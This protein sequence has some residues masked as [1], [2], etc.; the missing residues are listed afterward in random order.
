MVGA[1]VALGAVAQVQ[2]V[3]TIPDF[4]DIAE[5]IGGDAVTAIS[6]TQGSEDLHLV[7][8]RPSL[9]IKLRR[10]DVF[11]QLGL[12]GEHAWVPALLRTARN[13]RIRPGAPG[14]C[15]A[16]IG[17]PALEVPE[18]VHRGAGPD[19]HPRGNPHYNLDPVRMRIAARNILA[20]LVRVDADH[21]S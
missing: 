7:R 9:L 17:V 5:R 1:S 21:R 2:V 14:F 16:S 10:A 8:I 6:L 3:A 20:C 19:L 4:A 15:D 12:D 18:S 11:I 13:D